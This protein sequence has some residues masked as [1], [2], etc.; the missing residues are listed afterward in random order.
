MSKLNKVFDE[1]PREAFLPPDKRQYVN[2]DAPISI[3]FGQ[4]NSQPYTVKLMLEWLDVKPS[5]KVLDVGSGSGWTSALLARLVGDN[6]RVIAVERIPQLIHFG[7]SN[8]ESLGIKNIEFYKAKPKP[9]YKPHAP[10]DRILVSA[11]AQSLPDSLVRQLALNGKIVVPVQNSV[12]VGQKDSQGQMVFTSHPGFMF[13][14][15]IT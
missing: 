12:V 4:T 10:Y 13:V 9:G 6:G 15:L 8:C 2:I 5:Q 14:P 11:A 1:V 3:G 7:K